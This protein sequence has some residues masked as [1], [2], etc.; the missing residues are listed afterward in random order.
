[1]ALPDLDVPQEEWSDVSL[2]IRYEDVAQDGRVKLSALPHA[3]GVACW[4]ALLGD[5]PISEL[6]T[7]D[8]VV[9]I[10]SRVHIRAGGGP[11]S[12]VAPLRARG[13]FR[14]SH[15]RDAAGEVERLI[16]EL[17]ARVEGQRGATHGPAPEGAGA[18]LRVG[19]IH[20]EHV[21][22]RPFAP[23]GE[24]K[25]KR[26]PER[27]TSTGVPPA[28]YLWQPPER[29]RVPP[30]DARLIDPDPQPSPPIV[31]GLMHTDANQ[32]VNS[33]VYPDLLE[34]AVLTRLASLGRPTDVLAT[35]VELAYRKPCFAGD[36]LELSTMLYERGDTVGAV[37]AFEGPG[38]R[39]RPHVYARMEF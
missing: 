19:E 8:G 13:A 20:A 38:R 15:T 14:L 6:S 22:T 3:L 32:H 36:T 33:L 31:F 34:Q 21:F 28:R 24:R 29:V 5:H 11:V 26:L 16:L 4:Q 27:I 25:L 2:T 7:E 30:A 37:A 10:L 39:G 17:F 9:P 1:M 18:T 35:S 12:A 23:A